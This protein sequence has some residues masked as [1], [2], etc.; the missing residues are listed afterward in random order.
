MCNT[1]QK[2]VGKLEEL[3]EKFNNELF[4]GKLEKPI[5][6]VNN[7]HN[8][9]RL[10]YGWCTV[11]KVWKNEDKADFYEIN[12]CSDFLNRDIKETSSTLIHEMVHLSNLSNGI[13]D[14][15]RG[16]TYHNKKFCEL[17]EKVG[18][19]V[20]YSKKYGFSHTELGEKLITIV[21]GL[22]DEMKNLELYRQSSLLDG[23]TKKK[24]SSK[25]YICP[26]CGLKV[27]ATKTVNIAC[28]DCNEIMIES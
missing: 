17:A 22:D 23:K 16:G 11:S 2:T 1:I 12:I 4:E 13:V 6:T 14:C 9:K 27:R 7:N 28:M 24:Q 3:F 8:K 26:S 5:I 21:D 20:E 19:I 10:A 18:L 25:L 15:S